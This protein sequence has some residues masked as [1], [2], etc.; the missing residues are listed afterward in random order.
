MKPIDMYPMISLKNKVFDLEWMDL[1][2]L[3]CFY[4][5]VFLFSNNLGINAALIAGVYLFLRQYKKNK[6]E[7]YTQNLIRFLILP[8][9]YTQSQESA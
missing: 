1:L 3:L 6:A 4:L 9:R 2:I 8:L 7:R 5:L